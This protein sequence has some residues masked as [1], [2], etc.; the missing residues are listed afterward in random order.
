VLD[1]IRM[2]KG[3]VELTAINQA[4]QFNKNGIYKIGNLRERSN[5]ESNN[6]LLDL[7]KINNLSNFIELEIDL[8]ISKIVS[9]QKPETKDHAVVEHQKQKKIYSFDKLKQLQNILLLVAKK[10]VSEKNNNGNNLSPNTSDNLIE[11]DED[12]DEDEA[13]LQYFIEIFTNVTRVAEIYTKLLANGCDLFENMTITVYCDQANEMASKQ[14]PTLVVSIDSK[15]INEQINNTRTPNNECYK[16]FFSNSGEP[17]KIALKDIS[18]FMEYSLELWQTHVHGV[19]NRFDRLNHFTIN[20]IIYLKTN[21]N[22]IL[23]NDCDSGADNNSNYLRHFDLDMIASVMQLASPHSQF[24]TSIFNFESFIDRI[25]KL[26]LLSLKSR[27][28]FIKNKLNL[29]LIN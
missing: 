7:N 22:K 29:K 9:G 28:F 10:S 6:G 2:R 3:Q 19:R 13:L 20:Q 1:E 14:Q 21:L 26:Y 27:I 16:L 23:L 25:K 8:Q 11:T 17:T 15:F 5:I 18:N 24:S 4:K 12:E